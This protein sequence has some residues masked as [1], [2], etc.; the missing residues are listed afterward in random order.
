MCKFGIVL[1]SSLWTLKT[2]NRS[3]KRERGPYLSYLTNPFKEKVPRSTLR[4]WSLESHEG[5]AGNSLESCGLEHTSSSIVSNENL[6]EARE[7]QLSVIEDELVD[8]ITCS[9]FP[10]NEFEHGEMISEVTSVDQADDS[11]EQLQGNGMNTSLTEDPEIE[12]T[13]DHNKPSHLFYDEKHLLMT[14]TRKFGRNYGR[15]RR[16]SRKQV[17]RKLNKVT[18]MWRKSFPCTPAQGL[19]SV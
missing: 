11:V 12:N 17:M 14:V 1:H 6:E 13:R 19:H 2:P 7:V 8:S 3:K 15:M 18:Y 16:I 5:N 9:K 10:K 4:F